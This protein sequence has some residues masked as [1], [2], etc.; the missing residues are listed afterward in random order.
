MALD[1]GGFPLQVPRDK[2]HEPMTSR[3]P[4]L[5]CPMQQK[6]SRAENVQRAFRASWHEKLFA[7]RAK[8]RESTPGVSRENANTCTWHEEQGYFTSK[9]IHPSGTL[10][11]AY[12]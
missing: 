2:S 1:A 7:F 9:K 8:R 4:Y 10:P 5:D 11:W 6:V 3:L 12:A